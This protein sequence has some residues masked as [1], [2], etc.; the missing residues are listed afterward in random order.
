M[1]IK[2][3][4]GNHIFFTG[5]TVCFG[6]TAM[7][8]KKK[9]KEKVE[10]EKVGEKASLLLRASKYLYAQSDPAVPR[11]G[12]DPDHPGVDGRVDHVLSVRVVV[13]VPLEHLRQQHRSVVY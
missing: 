6:Q 11:P 1:K 3:S 9:K 13:E 10:E 4:A 8:K 12:K 5:C 2:T 7:A